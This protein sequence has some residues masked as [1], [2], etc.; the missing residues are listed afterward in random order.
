M[1]NLTLFTVHVH[2]VHR[3]MDRYHLK[4]SEFMLQIIPLHYVMNTAAEMNILLLISAQV[5]IVS[6]NE[7]YI[8]LCIT[9]HAV[10]S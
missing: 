1:G 4:P 5:F 3:I 8:E 10:L 2:N 6:M 9:T 7:Y